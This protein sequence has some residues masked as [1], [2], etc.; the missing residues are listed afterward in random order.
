M[1][2]DAR[3]GRVVFVAHCILN[4]NSVVRELAVRGS[5]LSEV[6]RVLEELDLGIVQLPCPETLHAGLRRFWQTSDQ[7][8]SIGFR[9]LCKRLAEQAADLAEEFERNGIRVVAVIGIRRSPSCGVTETTRGWIGGNPVKATEYEVVK[10]PGVFMRV[11]K[12]VFEARGLKPLYADVDVSR[13]E[14]SAKE[15]REVLR[16][17]LCRR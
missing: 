8:D 6:V 2:G 15:L 10:E 17:A 14:D 5:L 1:L 3:S 9:K 16:D 4:Q 13:L 7:Y 11:L 12:K